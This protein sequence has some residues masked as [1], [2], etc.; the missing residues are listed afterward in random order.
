[1]TRFTDPNGLQRD[2]VYVDPTPDERGWYMLLDP[3]TKPFLMV[4]SK[5]WAHLLV[6]IINNRGSDPDEIDDATE[7][8][9]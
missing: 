1:L 9:A 6:E 5:A 7:K 3:D 4:R 2:N 8:P